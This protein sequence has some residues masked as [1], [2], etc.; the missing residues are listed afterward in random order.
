MTVSFPGLGLEFFVN[1]IAFSNEVFS[2]RWYGW[3]IAVAYMLSVGYAS[4][5]CK[6]YD[7]SSDHITDIAIVGMICGIIGA[8]LYYVAFAWDYFKDDPIRIITDFKNGG[9]AIY[10]GIIASIIGGAIVAKKN[11]LSIPA[12]LDVASYGFL[13]AQGIGRWGNFTNQ[14]A[15]G[16][17]TSLPWGMAS[18]NTGNVAV[19]PCFLYESL[20]CLLGF[21]LAHFVIRKI[22]RYKG[23]VF[24]FYL[25]W[26]GFERMIVE[27]L[28]TDSLYLPFKVFGY[29]PRVSQV[30]SALMFVG[31]IVALIVLRNRNDM[32]LEQPVLE[33]QIKSVDQT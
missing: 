2:M 9:L 25:I 27:G 19:H 1:P 17:P 24:I 21:A 31:G 15:F 13:L 10:G 5:R 8:R 29:A 32:R 26:Y 16:T 30:L 7:I 12:C 28:R 22:I 18:V 6:D 23:Q 14:E 4:I 20:W 33:K 3:I 11:K